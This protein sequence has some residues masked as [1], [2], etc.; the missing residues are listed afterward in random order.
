MTMAVYPRWNEIFIVFAFLRD[1]NLEWRITSG[2]SAFMNET[3]MSISTVAYR[4]FM[5]LCV[6]A[7]SHHGSTAVSIQNMVDTTY[8]RNTITDDQVMVE[9]GSAY[10]KV[11]EGSDIVINLVMSWAQKKQSRISGPK[12]LNYE[13][14]I[15]RLAWDI[16]HSAFQ[17]FRIQT[18]IQ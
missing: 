8:Q 6:A 18:E 5:L 13:P 9:G 10:G 1:G 15:Q 4:H 14:K 3:I 16:R 7:I 11:N 2:S 17:L 12:T